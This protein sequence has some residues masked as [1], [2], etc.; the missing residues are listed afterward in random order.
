MSSSATGLSSLQQALNVCTALSR[1]C[2]AGLSALPAEL[3]SSVLALAARRPP[4]IAVYWSPPPTDSGRSLTALVK[5]ASVS[6]AFRA[7]ARLA[8]SEMHLQEVHLNACDLIELCQ[9]P[10]AAEWTS[11]VNTL[12][13]DFCHDT[14]AGQVG[15]DQ[16]GPAIEQCTRLRHVHAEGGDGCAACTRNCKPALAASPS[17]TSL[18]L[19]GEWPAPVQ[20]PAGLI[21]LEVCVLAETWPV[22][23]ESYLIGLRHCPSL[24]TLDLR[25]DPEAA[26]G[27]FKLRDSLLPG[28]HLPS[29]RILT[30]SLQTDAGGLDLSWL[31]RPRTFQLHVQMYCKGKDCEDQ[32][33]ELSRVLKATDELDVYGDLPDEEQEVLGSVQLASC[34]MAFEKAPALTC[35]PR[36][37]FLEIWFWSYPAGRKPDSH[38][39]QL[40]WA[41]ITQCAGQVEVHVGGGNLEILGC[42]EDCAPDFPEPWLLTVSKAQLILG[43]GVPAQLCK[44]GCLENAASVAKRRACP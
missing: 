39:A 18:T 34:R 19:C 41:A 31:R 11:R 12:Y 1:I 23:L 43:D 14:A 5:Y 7:A 28:L 3:Q 25:L 30:L 38:A 10:R 26:T 4:R 16:L 2:G 44:T 33:L 35:L 22:N 29:L 37:A 21:S 36:A 13:I 20:Y 32:L 15:L 40:D 27:H 8:A 17:L 9:L 6:K 24:Q 42:I